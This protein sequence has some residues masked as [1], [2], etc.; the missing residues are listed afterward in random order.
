MT[1]MGS[2]GVGPV[3]APTKPFVDMPERERL[4][5]A[6]RHREK[7][8]D[9]SWYRPEREPRAIPTM[10]LTGSDTSQSSAPTDRA[11]T[12]PNALASGEYVPGRP[13]IPE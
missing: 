9:D 12:D 5:E 3:D 2:L 7:P 1:L 11:P 4:I 10:T 8:E 6:E 13:S